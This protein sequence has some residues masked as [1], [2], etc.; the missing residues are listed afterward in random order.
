MG[1]EY[2]GWE[3]LTITAMAEQGELLKLVAYKLLL[4][5]TVTYKLLVLV[6]VFLPPFFLI[7]R[8]SSLIAYHLRQLLLMW[9]VLRPWRLLHW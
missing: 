8:T 4:I 1:P 2:G 5:Y 9:C 3:F 6:L 7:R